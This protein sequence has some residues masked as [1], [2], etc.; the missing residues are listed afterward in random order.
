MI[1][2]ELRESDGETN[3]HLASHLIHAHKLLIENLDKLGQ[4]K[5]V[6]SEPTNVNTSFYL[7]CHNRLAGV[8][9]ESKR[10]ERERSN[11]EPFLVP[12]CAKIFKHRKKF[13]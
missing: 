9:I 11:S 6:K 7:P 12:L 5:R 1:D 3:S 2:P 13:A 10:V 4:S 8:S